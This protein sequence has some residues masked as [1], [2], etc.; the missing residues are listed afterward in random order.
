MVK[1]VYQPSSA[2]ALHRA[3][4]EVMTDRKNCNHGGQEY[5]IEDQQS[6]T[7][8]HQEHSPWVQLPPCPV[9]GVIPPEMWEFG[10]PLF[11]LFH[12]PCQLTKGVFYG[13]NTQNGLHHHIYEYGVFYLVLEAALKGVKVPEQAVLCMVVNLEVP[14]LYVHSIVWYLR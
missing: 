5:S 7:G 12:E 2:T 11:V 1:E 14:Q 3:F 4:L 10:V 6:Y 9:L 13:Y 8:W